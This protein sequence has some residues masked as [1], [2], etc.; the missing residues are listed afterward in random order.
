ME[1][2]IFKKKNCK[3]CENLSQDLEGVNLPLNLIDIQNP[4]NLDICEQ[5]RIRKTPIVIFRDDSGNK[6]KQ[7]N[8][9][10]DGSLSGELVI[11]TYNKLLKNE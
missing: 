9:K 5:Y 7:L 4:D 10:I 2:L 11:S 6:V 1:I 8:G 3:P